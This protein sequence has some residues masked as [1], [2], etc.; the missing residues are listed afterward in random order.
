M[1]ILTE[2]SGR[3]KHG[4]RLDRLQCDCGNIFE[5]LYN[6][7]KRGRT[8]SCGHCGKPDPKAVPIVAPKPEPVSTLTIEANPHERNSVAWLKWEI[9]TKTATAIDLEKEAREFEAKV[10]A[11]GIQPA[12]YG[13][14]PPDRLWI[15]AQNMANKLWQQIAR[16]S[17]ELAK[18]E[19][20]V[21][22]DSRPQADIARDK[23]AALGNL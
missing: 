10:R 17:N 18:A 21:K 4:Q 5:A 14:E 22:K 16:L 19:T 15:R 1:K 23:I 7:V 12:E 13:T 9:D 6:N 3:N 8:K 20:A 2:N 11:N